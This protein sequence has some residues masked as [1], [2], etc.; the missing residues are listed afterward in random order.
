[1]V[2]VDTSTA[3][4]GG[5]ALLEQAQINKAM[6]APAAAQVRRRRR[7]PQYADPKTIA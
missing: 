2:T 7:T 3:A 1:M 5:G 6:D 4:A